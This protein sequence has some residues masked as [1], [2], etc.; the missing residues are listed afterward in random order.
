[1]ALGRPAREPGAPVSTPVTFTSTYVAD[2]EVAYARTSNPTWEA[3]EDVLGSLEGG[4]ALTFASGLAAISAVVSLVPVGGV[5]VAPRH[6][7]SGTTAQL[8]ERAAAGLLTV[9]TVQAEDTT[10]I[11]EACDG[12][13]LLLPVSCVSDAGGDGAYGSPP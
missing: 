7:Y 5:V 11:V 13:D 10:G 4:S 2:G 12:A 6:A 9:R 1:M 3:L 8:A